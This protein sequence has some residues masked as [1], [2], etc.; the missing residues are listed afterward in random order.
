MSG[1]PAIPAAGAHDQATL[2]E[3]RPYGLGIGRG[4]GHLDRDA[5]QNREWFDLSSLSTLSA[6]SKAQNV[7]I[8]G[9]FARPASNATRN[10]T[11]SSYFIEISIQFLGLR[12]QLRQQA[13]P[14]SQFG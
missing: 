4:F 5:I 9:L 11:T 6:L 1:H 10:K 2:K 7:P 13:D 8:V 12:N 3:L 14:V